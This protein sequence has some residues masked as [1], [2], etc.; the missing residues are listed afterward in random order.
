FFTIPGIEDRVAGQTP[1]G[2]G[3]DHQVVLT[4]PTAVSFSNITP[5]SGAATVD[6]FTGNNST[7]VTINLKN[8][9]NA[10][11]TTITLLGVNDGT[12]TNDVA[13]Q[14]GVL[15][16]DTSG[17]GTVNAADITQ[18][19]RQSGNVAHGD[20]GANFREDTTA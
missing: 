1:A 12:N 3:I 11:R 7:T 8:V 4:F 13:L 15:L 6:S 14:M 20:P 5:T 2:A 19:R 16:G 10:Q 17:D 9:S 18:T